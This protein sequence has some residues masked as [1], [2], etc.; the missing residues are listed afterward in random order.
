LSF[1]VTVNTAEHEVLVHHADAR[2]H[3]IG[4]R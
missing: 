3:G 1:S 4:W 2:G